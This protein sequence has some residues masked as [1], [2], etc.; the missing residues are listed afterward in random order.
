[1]S[2]AEGKAAL[3]HLDSS[4][5][6]KENYSAIS[7]Q[8]TQ[9]SRKGS[10]EILYEES[11]SDKTN[12]T[13]ADM[14]E[15]ALEREPL[16]RQKEG[17]FSFNLDRAGSILRAVFGIMDS[18][19]TNVTSDRPI[20]MISL[21]KIIGGDDSKEGSPSAAPA[22]TAPA[23]DED[24]PS[25][26]NPVD[27]DADD[28]GNGQQQRSDVSETPTADPA[29]AEAN[30]SVKRSASNSFSG[31]DEDDD[32]DEEE[33]FVTGEAYVEGENLKQ[34]MRMTSIQDDSEGADKSIEQ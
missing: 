11:T 16:T 8:S 17:R 23:Q 19:S 32:D 7:T 1:M 6:S 20:S 15:R 12:L 33:G 29:T 9:L 2:V 10:V 14:S 27:D 26:L 31:D 22:S 3:A 30:S 4:S 18:S 21:S 13:T 28:F 25:N 34:A 5:A 24:T